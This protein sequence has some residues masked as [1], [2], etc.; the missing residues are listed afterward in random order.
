[1]N[2]DEIKNQLDKT[3]EKDTSSFTAIAKNGGK[4]NAVSKLRR[5]MFL[6]IVS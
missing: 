5:K 3:V 2:F 1:M 6:E 4:H